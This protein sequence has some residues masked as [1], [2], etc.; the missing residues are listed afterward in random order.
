MV[1]MGCFNSIVYK[2]CDFLCLLL[3]IPAIPYVNYQAY[4]NFR[5]MVVDANLASAMTA[6][7]NERLKACELEVRK[8]HR[9]YKE[10][11]YSSEKIRE[12]AS[13]VIQAA[14]RGLWKTRT[15]RVLILGATVCLFASMFMFQPTFYVMNVALRKGLVNIVSLLKSFFT[16]CNLFM[17]CFFECVFIVSHKYDFKLVLLK[18][19]K[20]CNDNV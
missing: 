18:C 7:L 4:L 9:T 14:R 2:A 3:F 17:P 19:M 16:I 8:L 13:P 10:A 11:G 15:K 20:L 12:M 5:K 6:P 1:T